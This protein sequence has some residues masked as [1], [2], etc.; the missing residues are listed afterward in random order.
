MKRHIAIFAKGGLVGLT[1]A[2]PVYATGTD[3]D[4]RTLQVALAGPWLGWLA[5][6]YNVK[7]SEFMHTSGKP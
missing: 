5:I 6:A 4:S 3:L 7:V 2:L 1:A